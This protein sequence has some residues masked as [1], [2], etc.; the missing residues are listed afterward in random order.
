MDEHD[1]RAA[2]RSTGPWTERE[3]ARQERIDRIQV[4]MDRQRGVS[5]NLAEA[6]ALARFANRFAKAFE[7]VRRA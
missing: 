2:G 4:R 6:A 3:V 5:A 7:H 1:Q